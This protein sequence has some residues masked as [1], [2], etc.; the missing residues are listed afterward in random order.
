[1]PTNLSSVIVCCFP[2]RCRQH[3]PPP[4]GMSSWGVCMFTC[5]TA[6]LERY[7]PC[8][9]RCLMPGQHTSRTAAAVV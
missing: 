5:P 9:A 1:V 6:G 2:A 3:A 4:A 7:R 8:P